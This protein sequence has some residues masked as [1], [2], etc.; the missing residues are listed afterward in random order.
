MAEVV[1]LKETRHFFDELDSQFPGFTQQLV[2]AF[3]DYIESKR[4]IVPDIFGNDCPYTHPH[5]AFSAELMH[6]HIA[7]PPS[8]FPEKRPQVDRKCPTGQ[9]DKDAALVYV[10]GELE[11][12]RYCL[13]AFLYPSAHALAGD[14]KTIAYL[15]R[16]AQDFKDTN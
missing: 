1:F 11:I 6:I 10:Q 8:K 9:P 12:D 14:D 4:E 16:L 5:S 2:E 13:V 7:I 3:R 15:A